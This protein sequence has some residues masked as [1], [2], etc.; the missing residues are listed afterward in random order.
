MNY[1]R[2]DQ[3]TRHMTS[4]SS[5]PPSL[6]SSDSF[7]QPITPQHSTV[8]ESCGNLLMS[9]GICETCP[10]SFPDLSWFGSWSGRSEPG[11]QAYLQM[12]MMK[13]P[14]IPNPPPSLPPFPNSL[15]IEPF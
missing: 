10:H 4:Q 5:P 12:P 6:L 2:N 7:T 9:T 13:Y 15:S 3:Q 1:L 8:C 11:N 14:N